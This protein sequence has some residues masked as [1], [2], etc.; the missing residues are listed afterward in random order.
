MHTV[1]KM[2]KYITTEVFSR[3]WFSKNNTSLMLYPLGTWP[4]MSHDTH[5]LY[6][7]GDGFQDH[8]IPL[9]KVDLTCNFKRFFMTKKFHEQQPHTFIWVSLSS[10]SHLECQQRSFHIC[11]WIGL[12]IPQTILWERSS[13][14]WIVTIYL[15]WCLSPHVFWWMKF[16]KFTCKYCTL[17]FSLC[18]QIRFDVLMPF[19][20]SM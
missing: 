5:Y 16:L 1:H 4:C 12:I 9:K 10:Q 8:I 15:Q 3:H 19:S 7:L 2:D 11:W 6:Y 14:Y 13:I 18:L 20:K 17:W